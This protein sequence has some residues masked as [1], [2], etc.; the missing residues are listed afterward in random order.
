MGAKVLEA[1]SYGAYFN[2]MTNCEDLVDETTR[3]KIRAEAERLRANAQ[4]MSRT[5]LDVLEQRATN[6]LRQA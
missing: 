2:V 4:A 1:A 5:V 6:E 3:D